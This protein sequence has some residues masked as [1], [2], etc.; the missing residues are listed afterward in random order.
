M[1][2]SL[3]SVVHSEMDPFVLFPVYIDVVP[4]HTHLNRTRKHHQQR[5]LLRCVCGWVEDMDEN[6]LKRKSF[7]FLWS[8]PLLC[9][10]TLK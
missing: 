5:H 3:L 2:I 9:I 10:L 7:F 6:V 4:R 1:C 8:L